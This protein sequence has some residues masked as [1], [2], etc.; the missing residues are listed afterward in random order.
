VYTI[1]FVYTIVWSFDRKCIKQINKGNMVI[2]FFSF[3]LFIIFIFCF[4][5]LFFL[6]ISSLIHYRIHHT[7]FS[8]AFITRRR[9]RR[10]PDEGRRTRG[11]ASGC[12]SLSPPRP[13]Q[14]RGSASWR[15]TPRGTTPCLLPWQLS[16]CN[17]RGCLDHPFP[18]LFIL[19]SRYSRR[20]RFCID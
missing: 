2:T 3:Y 10:V 5:P 19:N 11:T 1:V 4:S 8:S 15:L 6:F 17:V 13:R 18:W 7:H 16:W 20:S 14:A 12:T 9:G